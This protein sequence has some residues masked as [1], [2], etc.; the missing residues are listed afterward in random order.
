MPERPGSQLNSE[1]FRLIEEQL[2]PYR[3]SPDQDQSEAVRHN[4]I[5]VGAGPVGLAAAI[6][7]SLQGIPVII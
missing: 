1:G 3:R 2:Y 5:V 7:L 6:D 4:V